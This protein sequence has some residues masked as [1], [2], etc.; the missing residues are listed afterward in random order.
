M[1]ANNYFGFTHGSTQ[2]GSVSS[3]VNVKCY[4]QFRS[5]VPCNFQFLVISHSKGNNE[6]VR[7]VCMSG[8][9]SANRLYDILVD[10]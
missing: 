1:A 3:Y 6:V 8:P 5:T 7:R 4:L 10:D 9:G 2:Y